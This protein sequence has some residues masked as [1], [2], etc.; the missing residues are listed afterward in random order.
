V[1][2]RLRW[3]LFAWSK[4]LTAFGAFDLLRIDAADS[5]PNPD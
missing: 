1:S 4:R 5:V 2:V 3:A